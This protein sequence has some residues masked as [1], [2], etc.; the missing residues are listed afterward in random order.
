MKK[1]T[2][3][4]AIA[5]LFALASCKKEV[6]ETEVTGHDTVIHTEVETP[7]IQDTIE[8]DTEGTSVKVNA[9]GMSVDTKNGNDKT[10]VEV[11]GGGA[12]V[13]VKK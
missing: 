10:K 9:D 1:T 8:D 4:M 11:N 3:I 5:A 12:E 13:E 7:V 6:K 2:S